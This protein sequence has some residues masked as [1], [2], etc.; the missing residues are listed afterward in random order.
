[1][2]EWTDQAGLDYTFVKPEGLLAHYTTSSVV[3]HILPTGKLRL[4]PYRLM[5]DPVENKDI[6]PSIAWRGDPPD[7]DR[8]IEEV[9]ELLR[10]ARD[11]MR[12]LS[13]TRDA[14]RRA[15]YSGFDCCWAR[16]RMWELYGDVHRGVCLLFDRRAL[17]RAITDQW[18]PEHTYIRDV[19]YSREGIAAARGPIR[20]MVDQRIFEG[21]ERAQAV[22]E[23]I[24][25]K[26]QGLATGCFLALVDAAMHKISTFSRQQVDYRV[27]V[28]R[29]GPL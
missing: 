14:D 9:Y 13:F 25:V 4:S 2:N 24:G 3:E 12:V 19:D 23:Y 21:R 1:L 6:L 7:A 16:P 18:P 26:R 29:L 17:D 5:R 27:V 28:P 20:T 8:A 15:E 10:A 11:R 22:A